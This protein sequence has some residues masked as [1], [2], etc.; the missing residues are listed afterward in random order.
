MR[1]RGRRKLPP[2]ERFIS[3]HHW[4]LNAPAFLRL[5]GNAV[6]LMAM[7]H[8]RYSG[9]NNGA[10]SMSVR[11]AAREV[12]CSPN[13]AVSL[14]R[15]LEAAGFIATTQKGAFS[16]KAR[17]ATTWRLTWLPTENPNA[18]SGRTEATKEFMRDTRPD[19][20]E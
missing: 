11:E 15:E 13:H 16:W 2:G 6:K 17:H 4:L 14:F 9:G 10:I 12:G 5:R 1:R 3:W 19:R 18:L 7:L 20:K 8:K